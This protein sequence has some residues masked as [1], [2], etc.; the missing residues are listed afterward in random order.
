MR[1][2]FLSLC[3]LLVAGDVHATHRALLI[4]IND[5]TASRLGVPAP[6]TPPRDWVTLNGAVNDVEVLKQ[7]LLLVYGADPRDIVT[8]TDQAATRDA[9]LQSLKKLVAST[10]KGDVVLF[11]FAGHGSQRVNSLSDERDKLDE[12]LV[13]ADSPL[14]VDDI[15]DKE[16]RVHFN[17]ILDRDAALTVIL[18]NCHSGSG[19]RG[20]AT[21]ARARGVKRDP[22]DI[23][24]RTNHGPRPETRG[25]LVLSAA[26]DTEDAREMRDAEGKFHGIFSWALIRALRDASSGEAAMETFLR[27]QARMRT[28]PP[29]QSPVIAGNAAAKHAP[30]LGTRIDRRDD[31]I[32]VA[33]GKSQSDS[34]VLQGGWANGLAAGTEL[35]DPKTPVRL[36]ITEVR[37]LGQSIARVV[38][39]PPP[40]TGALVEVVGW[41]VPPGPPLRV[42]IPRDS[43]TITSITTFAKA[44]NAE[45]TRRGLRWVAN[46][47]ERTP[48]HVLRWGGGWWEMVGPR[49]AVERLGNDA[50]AM[51][52]VAKLP[53]GTSLFVQLPAPAA[54]AGVIGTVSV[55]PDEADY[56]LVGRYANQQ[57]KYAWL[58]PLVNRRDQRQTGLPLQTKWTVSAP[59][60]QKALMRLRRIQA[61]HTLESPPQ[62]RF[63]YRLQIRRARDERL[64]GEGESIVSDTSYRLYLRGAMPLSPTVKKRSV[65]AFVVDSYGRSTL[66]FPPL[67]SGSVE[68]RFPDSGRPMDIPLHGSEFEA[69]DPFGVDTYFLLS[70][71]EPLPN[72]NILEWDGVRAPQGPK[73][74]LEQLLELTAS[75]TRSQSVLTPATWSIERVAFE[76]IRSRAT[77]TPR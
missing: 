15:R 19:A 75:G 58:R 49:G 55:A 39:G 21:G 47:I 66:L 12:S 35:R 29:F 31:R 30:F 50:A 74:P 42:S 20:L 22:R 37:G 51:A 32:V 69:S 36:K 54:M 23:A 68:N 18:D 1:L 8:L 10:A 64:V 62:T 7:M 9:I 77:K 67:D 70:T 52:A 57:L 65:Y 16:L 5:Y 14:G 56:I 60:I 28:E 59:D 61:W 24:D 13:P 26:E 46:P 41:A 48:S 43:R 53:P 3:A 11:Y 2:T 40:K 25:A 34:V 76:S 72:P 4:G 17:R 73:S 63:P 45:A 6:G 38:S 44:L 33:V 71:D 27:A